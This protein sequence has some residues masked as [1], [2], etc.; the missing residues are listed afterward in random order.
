MSSRDAKGVCTLCGLNKLPKC[1]EGSI[2]SGPCAFGTC[3]NIKTLERELWVF[4]QDCPFKWQRV[5]GSAR[6]WKGTRYLVHAV[7]IEDNNLILVRLPNGKMMSKSKDS[8][9]DIQATNR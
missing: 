6:S 5:Q 8:F 3:D 2:P 1:E 4:M 7:G 9:E